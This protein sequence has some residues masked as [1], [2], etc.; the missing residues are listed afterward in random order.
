MIKIT[1]SIILINSSC[2][3]DFKY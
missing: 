3:H 2:M 1:A